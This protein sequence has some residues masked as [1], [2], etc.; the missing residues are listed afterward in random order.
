MT[1]MRRPPPL[2]DVLAALL[3]DSMDTLL[4]RACLGDAA[5]AAGAWQT[6][7]ADAGGLPKA[8][9]DR[10]A[11]RALMPLLHHSL[12]VHSIAVAEPSLAILRAA[13][14]WETRRAAEIRAILRQIVDT[15]HRASIRAITI[16]GVAA[17]AVAYPAFELRHCHDIALL[18]EKA[19]RI[20]VRHLLT[21]TGFAPASETVG[22]QQR[23]SID[24]VHEGGL[25]VALHT[26]PW[27][28]T[29]VGDPTADLRR[30]AVSAELDGFELTVLNPT[31]MLLQVCGRGIE[32]T[33]PGN[34]EWI[35]DAAMILRRQGNARLDWA[36][37]VER[38]KE[39]GL[40]FRLSLRLDYLANGLGLAI[41]PS[42]T[43]ALATAA[44]QGDRG[45]WGRSLSVARGAF[46]IGLS[47]MLRQ[48]GW[49]SRLAI[50]HWALRRSPR[51]L[52]RR[53][54][55]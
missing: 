50:A 40:A 4:L 51:L 33:E 18:V 53:T 2:A 21:A 28:S 36:A 55:P 48:G 19:E 8:L 35:A 54:P 47:A 39:Y 44:W 10:P 6:W 43:D 24:L 22:E 15:L 29:G 30:R 7:L 20:R 26:V 42:A 27:A 32:P 25:P 23:S 49:R 31:D 45:E 12:R 41:P 16:E 38:A 9:T 17:G 11:S 34:W 13:S 46:G 52:G 1:P 3:P 37:L 5:F 14:L